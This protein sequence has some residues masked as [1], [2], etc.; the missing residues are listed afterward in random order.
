MRRAL[1]LAR[2][3]FDDGEVPVGAVIWHE[4]RVIG[5]AWNQVE[6]LRDATA[7]AEILAITQ[8]SAA[9]GDWRL[10]GAK[11]VVTKEPCPMCSGAI[12]RARISTVVY[13]AADPREGG[14]TVFGILDWPASH[15]RVEVR[16][17]ILE[18]ESAALLR[19]FF[20]NRRAN[21]MH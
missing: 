12:V 18:N 16:G 3:A 2:N 4:D 20:R 8:A 9:V 6:G 14:A 19:D 1:R 15:H 11:L 13:G 21:P 5:S 7:H 17:G 10:D